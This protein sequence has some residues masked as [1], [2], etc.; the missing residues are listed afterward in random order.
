MSVFF[1]VWLSVLFIGVLLAIMQSHKNIY[2]DGKFD[3]GLLQLANKN[4]IFVRFKF[5]TILKYFFFDVAVGIPLDSYSSNVTFLTEISKQS[6]FMLS[7]WFINL[8]YISLPKNSQKFNHH[9]WHYTY[10][11]TCTHEMTWSYLLFLKKYI[12]SSL[13]ILQNACVMSS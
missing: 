2:I 11:L 5:C 1:S 9:H 12:K 10:L 4:V 7:R 8:G 13:Y 6:S 3:M